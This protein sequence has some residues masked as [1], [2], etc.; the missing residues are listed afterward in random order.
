MKLA[1]SNLCS[2]T[3]AA[4]IFLCNILQS[5]CFL[6]FAEGL[7]W[8]LCSITYAH[9]REVGGLP[10]EDVAIFC[11]RMRVGRFL[12]SMVLSGAL[13]YRGTLFVSHSGSITALLPMAAS[14]LGVLASYWPPPSASCKQFTFLFPGVK[15]CS[16]FL[17]S[18]WLSCTNITPNKAD[19]FETE[20]S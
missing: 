16:M 1:S 2:S 12:L 8:S 18:F 4:T 6:D 7:T 5:F 3:L 15:P 13:G 11:L 19:T 14:A 20:I 17:A 10:S 9:S